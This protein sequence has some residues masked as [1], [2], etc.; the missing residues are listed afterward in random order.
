LRKS[1]AEYKAESRRRARAAGLCIS[2]CSRNTGPGRAVC[3]QCVSKAVERKERLRLR[4]RETRRNLQ[5]LLDLEGTGD[6]AAARHFYEDAIDYYERALATAGAGSKDVARISEK[7]GSALWNSTD[8]GKAKSYFERALASYG[9]E[10]RA[11]EKACRILLRAG[12]QFW[13]ESKTKARIPL[14]EQ[15]IRAAR[16]TDDASLKQDAGV[17]MANT[18]SLLGRHAEATSYLRE[19]D[20]LRPHNRDETHARYENQRGICAAAAGDRRSAFRH[21]KLA[22]KIAESCGSS[23]HTTVIL[24][25]HALWALAL[26]DGEKALE[27]SERALDVARHQHVTW[28]IPYLSLRF[29][30]LL[31]RFGQHD[32][33]HQMLRDAITYDPSAMPVTR[34]LFTALGTPLALSYGDKKALRRCFFDDAFS[35]A[36]A[37][38]EPARIAGVAGALCLRLESK[39]SA[40]DIAHMLRRAVREVPGAD[41]CW[42]LCIDVA[43]FGFAA[44]VDRAR[45]LLLQRMKLR[46]GDVARAFLSLFDATTSKRRNQHKT[47]GDL[48]SRAAGQF[49]R[50]GWKAYVESC[51][52]LMGIGNGNSNWRSFPKAIGNLSRRERQIADLVVRGLTNREVASQLHIT[53]NTVESHMSSILARLGLRSRW[54]LEEIFKGV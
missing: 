40:Q 7:L 19:V 54:Q 32:L 50:L 53:E 11:S 41:L 26:A 6:V 39:S 28:R 48:F 3:G 1:W 47:A 51:R 4:T 37:S 5:E 52:N 38:G 13:V 30:H 22:S 27:C 10:A 49:D 25:D 34:V 9:A 44:D 33:A 20:L 46:N 31:H 15:T 14:Y 17:S 24:D 45:G 12:S 8:P 29:A 16:A 42:D 23:Y 43:R 18:L 35:L 21:F 2:C 36:L